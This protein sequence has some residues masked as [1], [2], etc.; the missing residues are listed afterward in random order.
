MKFLDL[1]N[2]LSKMQWDDVKMGGSMHYKL[3]AECVE[4]I[5]LYKTSGA[6][7]DFAACCIIKYA[8]RNIRCNGKM[9][10]SDLFKIIHYACLL[11][12]A[13]NE[14]LVQDKGE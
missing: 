7:R 9:S 5:D 10:R 2:E 6:L 14:P 1:M 3:G 8:Y 11:L 13:D 12:V 4:P